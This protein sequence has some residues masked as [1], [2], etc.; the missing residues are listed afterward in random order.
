MANDINGWGGP[1]RRESTPV[2]ITRWPP[3][4]RVAAAAL[5]I[6]LVVY[7]LITGMAYQKLVDGVNDNRDSITD[8]KSVDL[9]FMRL[10]NEAT[11]AVSSLTTSVGYLA[12]DVER[13]DNSLNSHRIR[14][15]Q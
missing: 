2:T 5:V 12:N 10:L 4:V 6:T 11:N 13:V 8:I 15:E 9:E 14:S 7:I 3:G 1:E